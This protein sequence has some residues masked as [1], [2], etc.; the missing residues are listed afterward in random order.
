MWADISDLET[1][2][3]EKRLKVWNSGGQLQFSLPPKF[4]EEWLFAV[5]QV[6]NQ[7]YRDG[8]HDGMVEKVNQFKKALEVQDA[9]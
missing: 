3:V 5:V 1:Q 9:T 4:P 2:L 8:I 7:A 6:A